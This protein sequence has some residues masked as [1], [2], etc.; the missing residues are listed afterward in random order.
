MPTQSKTA[1][2]LAKQAVRKFTNYAITGLVAST[3]IVISFSLVLILGDF[4]SL[5]SVA[6]ALSF[7][8]Y[9]LKRKERLRQ[10]LI[11]TAV[12][13][14]LTSLLL[15]QAFRNEDHIGEY[16]EMAAA[17]LYLI[18]SIFMVLKPLTAR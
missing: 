8:F 16:P 11:S 13:F 2:M 1:K 10:G 4:W 17:I 18:A 12:F 15:F 3:F 14:G 9:D 6:F 7:L 5:P